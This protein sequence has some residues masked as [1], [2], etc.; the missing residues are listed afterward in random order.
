MIKILYKLLKD[1]CFFKITILP[2]LGKT[3]RILN[4]VIKNPNNEA[5]TDKYVVNSIETGIKLKY[6]KHRIHIKDMK[7]INLTCL[8]LKKLII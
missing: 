6:I 3:N 8:I 4:V 1:L 5:E 2:S 7:P